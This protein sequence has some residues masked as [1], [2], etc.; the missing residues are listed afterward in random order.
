MAYSTS[1]LFSFIKKINF[2]K[3]AGL[4]E[5]KESGVNISIDTVNN[6]TEEDVNELMI[7]IASQMRLNNLGKGV[8]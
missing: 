1:F 7:R 5:E 3:V 6:N 8:R 4:L 2:K